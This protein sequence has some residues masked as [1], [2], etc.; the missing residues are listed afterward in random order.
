MNVVKDLLAETSELYFSDPLF[1]DQVDKAVSQVRAAHEK[2][3][4]G[5]EETA[6]VSFPVLSDT[7]RQQIFANVAMATFIAYSPKGRA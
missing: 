5:D 1:R 3:I 7:Q 6:S 4:Q 2:P